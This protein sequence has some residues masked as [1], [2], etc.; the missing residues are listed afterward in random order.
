MIQTELSFKPRTEI[1]E[2]EKRGKVIPIKP[3]RL[4]AC[5]C[6]MVTNIVYGRPKKYV[7][8]HNAKGILNNKWKGGKLIKRDQYS[9][10]RGYA[11]TLIK[12]H[13]KANKHGYVPDHVLVAEKA[14]GKT[15]PL[16]AVVHHIDKNSLNNS[17]NNLVVCQDT[18]YHS[19]IHQREV[20]LNACGHASW[21]KCQFCHQYEDPANMMIK[22]KGVRGS[23][24]KDCYNKY[25]SESHKRRVEATRINKGL[26]SY[27]LKG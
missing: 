10:K 4:C 21:R 1:P 20:A 6:G 12:S 8:G 17:H 24:H 27:R 16:T 5:G 25:Q 14:L 26:F 15:L 11:F 19:L 7:H 3:F 23:R 2:T 9:A 13:P 18:N 22:W